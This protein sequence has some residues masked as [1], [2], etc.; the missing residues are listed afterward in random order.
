MKSRN[1]TVQSY[2]RFGTNRHI[3]IHEATGRFYDQQK[4][5]I[6]QDGSARQGDRS[7]QAFGAEQN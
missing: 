6:N 5:P 1:G 2:Q 7:R 4:T 3:H